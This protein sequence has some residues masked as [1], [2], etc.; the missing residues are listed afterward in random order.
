MNFSIIYNPI[1]T[2]FSQA[3]LDHLIFK[4]VERGLKL[5]TIAKS[6][7][8][9]HVI[10]LIKELDPVSDYLITFG[11][12]GTVNEA[13]RAFNEIEQ[14]SVYAHISVG[15]TNDM[16]NNFNLYRKDAIKSIDKLAEKGKET[17]MDSLIVNGEPVCYV[18]SFGYIAAVPYLVNPTLKKK[19]GHSA[20]VVAAL[21][22]LMRGPQKI[23][24]TYTA[25]G[26]TKDTNILLALITTSKGMGG[27]TLYNDVDLNDGKFEVCLIHDITPALIA[28][29]FGEYLTDSIDLSKYLEYA[30]V[31]STDELHIKFTGVLP[32]DDLDNDGNKASFSLTLHENELHYT[33]G[34]KIKILMPEN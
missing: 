27:I 6:E 21:P 26:K 17:V 24:A 29:I 2:K 7:Y 3:A 5:N 16:A 14:H 20:Y 11:G 19:L 32:Y 23:K 28:K 30:D 10:K 8:S 15:T 12:D 4:F 34:K 33:M 18:S 13:F 22:P 31:F 25:N 1:A 9:G